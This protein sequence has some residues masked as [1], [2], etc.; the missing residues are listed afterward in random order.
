L[1]NPIKKRNSNIIAKDVLNPNIQVKIATLA[2]PIK[3]TGRRP[4]LSDNEPQI[5]TSTK[6]VVSLVGY[7]DK[8]CTYQ[9]EA[10]Q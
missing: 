10:G 1:L 5:K 4:I 6:Q 7:S 9:S 2:R 8:S 3:S